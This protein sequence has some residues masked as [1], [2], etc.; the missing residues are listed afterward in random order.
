MDHLSL[1]M[2]K[3]EAEQERQDNIIED[4]AGSVSVHSTE[5]DTDALS[6]GARDVLN[7]FCFHDSSPAPEEFVKVISM[8]TRYKVRT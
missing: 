7:S 8:D 5:T 6:E 3:H 4:I 1:N 2:E